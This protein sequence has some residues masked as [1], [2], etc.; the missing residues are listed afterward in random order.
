MRVVDLPA[1]PV[2]YTDEGE[3]PPVVLLHGLLIDETVWDTTIPLLPGGIRYIRPTLP[4]GAHRQPMNADADLSLTGQVHLIADFLDALD[5][6]DV[7]LVHSD[8]G[9]SLFL[10]AIGRD[11]RVGA[12]VIMPCEAFDNFPPGLPGRMATLATKLPGGITLAAR[13]LRIG[14]LRRTPL[15]FGWMVRRPIPEEVVRR[16][17]Q[18]SLTEPGVRRDLEKYTATRFRADD[19]IRDTNALRDFRGEC[20][21]LW[22]PENRVMPPEHGRRLAELI[23]QSRLVEIGDAYVL[24]MLDRP[25][26]V[27]REI[28]TF[29]V[30]RRDL[31]ET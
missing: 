18:P 27:A 28:G 19:L 11:E 7:T 23:P 21:I 3:G 5:L 17:T 4:L 13:Q 15:L 1:G 30:E 10:T 31:A 22:S 24:S 26:D 29:L 20:L 12:M 16:W 8:W 25:A 6:R 9:G 2:E 14:W